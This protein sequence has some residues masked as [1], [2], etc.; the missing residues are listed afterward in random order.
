VVRNIRSSL[1]TSIKI[2]LHIAFL[3]EVL[4]SNNMKLNFEPIK[5]IPMIDRVP[6]MRA[7]KRKSWFLIGENKRK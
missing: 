6:F 3:N 2:G 4:L 1:L 5:N 7:S